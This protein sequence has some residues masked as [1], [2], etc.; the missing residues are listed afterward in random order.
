MD[1]NPHQFGGE[2]LVVEERRM[3]PGSYPYVQRGGMRGGRGGASGQGNGRGSIQG[4][5]G[6]LSQR[7][8]GNSST[9]QARGRGGAQAA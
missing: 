9:S 4:T 6:G 2:R 1:A 5:R 3:K 8:R 7:G